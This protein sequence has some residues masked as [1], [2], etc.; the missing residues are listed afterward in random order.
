MTSEASVLPRLRSGLRRID[1][2]AS[3]VALPHSVFA[4]PFALA[5]F[6]LAARAGALVTE[7]ESLL[8]HSMLGRLLVVIVAIFSARTAALAFNRLVDANIDA[9]NPRTQ[10][11]EIPAGVISRRSVTFVVVSMSLIFI[12]CAG[13]LGTHCLVLAPFVLLLLLGYSFFKRFSS[14]SHL[15]L[16]FAL[17]AAP[18]GAWWVLR[19]EVETVPL[20]LMGGVTCWVAGFDM[21]YSCQDVSF[22]RAHGLH[23]L[24]ARF[25]VEK[26][27]RFSQLSHFLAFI[28]FGLVGYSARLGWL[29]LIPLSLIGIP[30]FLQHWL[31]RRQELAHIQ[32]AFFTAN[33]VMS[34]AYLAALAFIL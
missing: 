10:K 20:L 9:D 7:H 16:G 11:R 15:I 31:L 27:F 24:P 18:G 12:G 34:V 14:S 21:L 5:S 30:L 3:L 13:L 4:L 25:G 8:G 2:F 19:P 6:L 28:L 22:D 26:T 17:A 1:E 23:S 33:G 32:H 29:Y